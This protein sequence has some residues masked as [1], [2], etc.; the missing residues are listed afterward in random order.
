M[1]KWQA[2]ALARELYEAKSRSADKWAIRNGDDRGAMMP[3]WT[4]L[5][6]EEQYVWQDVADA[7]AR[8]LKD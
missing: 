4:D 5:A 8:F 7:A 3:K 6:D 2:A 1:M